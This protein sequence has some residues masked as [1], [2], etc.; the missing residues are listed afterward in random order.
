[1]INNFNLYIPLNNALLKLG[2]WLILGTGSGEIGCCVLSRPSFVCLL[3][4][5]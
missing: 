4:N 3:F 2:D 1:M 5:S